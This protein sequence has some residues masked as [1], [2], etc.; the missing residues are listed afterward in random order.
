MEE[1][2]GAGKRRRGR[3][4]VELEYLCEGGVSWLELRAWGT[5][6]FGWFV[7]MGFSC[8]YKLLLM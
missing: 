4:G 3:S 7:N 5:A 1:E 2:K 6:G 8:G